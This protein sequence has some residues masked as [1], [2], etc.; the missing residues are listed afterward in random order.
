MLYGLQYG[1]IESL[2]SI[3]SILLMSERPIVHA[4]LLRIQRRLGRDVFPVVDQTYYPDH[5]EMVIS[6]DFPAVVKVRTTPAQLLHIASCRA[7]HT[8]GTVRMDDAAERAGGSCARRLRQDGGQGRAS[9]RGL[10]VCHGCITRILHRRDVHPRCVSNHFSFRACA[11][12]QSHRAMCTGR[13]VVF[14]AV[15]FVLGSCVQ[16]PTTSESRKSA[17][18]CVRSSACLCQARG[19]PTR[20]A[21]LWRRLRS[22]RSIV[23]GPRNAGEATVWKCNVTSTAARE[24]EHSPRTR[25]YDGA[26]R[27][28]VALIS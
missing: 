19:K 8:G 16:E 24:R 11:V 9:V 28:S 27:Y 13:C 6:P 1:L 17:R 20:G 25:L 15:K 4:E 23:C 14:C 7:T 18:V 12:A 22:P 26:A 2:N 21:R 10:C 3:H 5:R